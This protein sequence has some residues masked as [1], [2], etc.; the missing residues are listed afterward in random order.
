MWNINMTVVKLIQ[1]TLPPNLHRN[2]IKSNNW[3]INRKCFRN[4]NKGFL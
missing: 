1:E 3:R 2:E 4:K